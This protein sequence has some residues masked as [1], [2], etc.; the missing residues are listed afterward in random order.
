MPLSAKVSIISCAVWSL[1]ALV[2]SATTV[3]LNPSRL[4]SKAV[5][6]TQKSSARPTTITSSMRF[7]FRSFSSFVGFFLVPNPL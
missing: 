1:T 5:L 2:A 6:P 7:L 3:T 4:A